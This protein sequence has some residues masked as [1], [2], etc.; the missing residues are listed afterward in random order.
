MNQPKVS[1]IIP[2]YNAEKTLADCLNSILNQT[3]QNYEVIAVDNN[4]TDKTKEI[5]LWYQQKD[6]KVQYVFEKWQSRGAACNAGINL[7]IGKIIA[8][9]HADCFVSKNW[10]SQLVQPIIKENELAVLGFSADVINNFWTHNTQKADWFFCQRSLNCQYINLI[11]GKN[12]ASRADLLKSLMF[13]PQLVFLEDL[14]LYLRLKSHA[15]IRFLP[16]VIVN[17]YHKSTFASVFRNFFSRGFWLIKIYFKYRRGKD[18]KNE[19][20]FESVSVLN[21]ITLP[22]WLIFNFFTTG[23]GYASFLVVT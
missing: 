8:M 5:I 3:Y 6:P 2:V 17:H 1:V 13:D 11:D 7:A 9:L 4:S 18:L 14:D 20:M 23:F 21:F 19:L 12:F 22:I 16:D 10:L 15:K